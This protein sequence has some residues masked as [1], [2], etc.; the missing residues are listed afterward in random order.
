MNDAVWTFLEDFN[1]ITGDLMFVLAVFGFLSRERIRRWITR[2]RF[3]AEPG[4]LDLNIKWETIIFTVSNAE[5]PIWVIDQLQPAH[6]GLIA[7]LE[8]EPNAQIIRDHAVKKGIQHSTRTIPSA[9]D[10]ASARSAARYLLEELPH[11][12]LATVAVDVTGGKVPMSLG[13]FMAAEEAGANSLYVS[14]KFDPALKKPDMRTATI[15]SISK[16]Q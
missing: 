2:N 5:V 9:D 6:I 11:A 14:S 13:A 1:V 16:Q 12:D 8:S 10:L 15:I 7:T 4:L 3:P